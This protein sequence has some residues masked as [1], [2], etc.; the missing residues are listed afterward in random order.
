[1]IPEVVATPGR[2]IGKIADRAL[3]HTGS[4]V[5]HLT[6]A[7]DPE[8]RRGR[9]KA[10]QEGDDGHREQTARDAGPP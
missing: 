2:R 6:G 9:G 3:D 4:R 10:E 7:I 1:M 8:L 5:G